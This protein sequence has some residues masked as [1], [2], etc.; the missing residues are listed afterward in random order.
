MILAVTMR[1]RTWSTTVLMNSRA[2][3][4]AVEPLFSGCKQS[5]AKLRDHQSCLLPTNLANSG[6]VKLND[7]LEAK[8]RV[9]DSAIAQKSRA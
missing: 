9:M 3:A 1:M 2:S 6:S 8:L 5:R 4:L 7:R